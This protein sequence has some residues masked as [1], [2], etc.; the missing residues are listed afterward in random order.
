MSVI[1]PI[2][3]FPARSDAAFKTRVETFFNSEFPTAIDQIN[4]SISAFNTNDLRGTSS[5][6][7][8]PNSGGLGS[9]VFVTQT[10]KSW[11]PGQWVTIGYTSDGRE[12][13]AGV[14]QSYSGTSLTVG[15]KVV[16]GHTTPRTAWQIAFSPP[17]TDIGDEEVIVHTGNGYGS[18]NTKRRRYSTI[19]K[20]VG[21]SITY[22][23]S[24]TLGASFTINIDG[25]YYVKRKDSSST[26]FQMGVA[27]N[28][29]SG[30]VAYPSGLTFDQRL[31]FESGTTDV[32]DSL[33]RRFSA[34]N[35][36]APHDGSSLSNGAD[37]NSFMIVRR[38]A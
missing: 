23:D 12:Y 38:I 15:V 28:P 26:T 18:T 25:T 17:I 4:A 10:G 34:G 27:L 36:I 14:V 22:S 5:T 9:K 37:D 3:A 7:Y 13:A 30:T 11:V 24:A 6:S 33:I 31:L 32:K 29:T 19:F 8:T 2:A 1:D 16:S 21:T 20:N 35:I